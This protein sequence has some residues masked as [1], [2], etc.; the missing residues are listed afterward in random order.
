[1]SIHLVGVPPVVVSY[2][3]D[4]AY[5]FGVYLMSRPSRSLWEPDGHQF[6]QMGRPLDLVSICLSPCPRSIILGILLAFSTFLSF[7]W[8]LPHS[9]ALCFHLGTFNFRP[10]MWTIYSGCPVPLVATSYPEQCIFF[11]PSLVSSTNL[12]MMFILDIASSISLIN[13]T[14]RSS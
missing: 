7:S 3:H 5:L 12:L 1:M 13:M 8:M 4:L 14:K 11:G 9:V 2:V 10:A 6:I